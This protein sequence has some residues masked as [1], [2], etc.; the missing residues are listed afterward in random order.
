MLQRGQTLTKL[1]N[2]LEIPLDDYEAAAPS[3]PT[4]MMILCVADL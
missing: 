4:R 2:C 1:K 3:V